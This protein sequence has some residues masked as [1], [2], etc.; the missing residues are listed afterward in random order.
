MELKILVQVDG[1]EDEEDEEGADVR[2]A[3]SSDAAGIRGQDMGAQ[4]FQAGAT[5]HGSCKADERRIRDI[6][7]G[8][9]EL[10]QMFIAS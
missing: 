3:L 2:A 5:V 9:L 8:N 4:L 7:L 6:I 1:D 10:L